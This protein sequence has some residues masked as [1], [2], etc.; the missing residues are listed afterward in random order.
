MKIKI[1]ML[2]LMCLCIAKMSLGQ[3]INNL[4]F[5]NAVVLN[6]TGEFGQVKKIGNGPISMILIA[7][8]GFGWNIYKDFM[9]S[10]K[11]R[12]TMYAVTLPGSDNTAPLPM[13]SA[14]LSYAKK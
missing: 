1:S 5:S 9:K 4:V 7:D 13:P 8:A 11:K 14:G 12:Y 10:N 2:A 3:E 6:E